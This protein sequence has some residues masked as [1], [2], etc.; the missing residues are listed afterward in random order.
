MAKV[1]LFLSL[2]ES[3]SNKL[4]PKWAKTAKWLSGQLIKAIKDDDLAKVDKLLSAVKT[5]NLYKGEHE[6]LKQ[7]SLSALLLGA[8]QVTPDAKNTHIAKLG[9]VPPIIAP[10]L[11][12]MKALMGEADKAVRKELERTVQKALAQ[13]DKVEKADIVKT[14]DEI[15]RQGA[16][17]AGKGMINITA[18]LHTSR[19]SA[20]GFLAEADATGLTRY[21]ITEQLDNRICPVCRTMH[22]K[23][24]D[25][26][27]AFERLDRVLQVDDPEELKVIA[28]WVKQNQDN[29]SRIQNM[30][31]SD[32]VGAGMS[33]PPYHP[34]CRGLLVK[35]ENVPAL[36]VPVPLAPLSRVPN[37]SVPRTTYKDIRNQKANIKLEGTLKQ[38][39]VEEAWN[40]MFP[41]VTP[42]IVS[43]ELSDMSSILGDKVVGTFEARINPV[44]TLR[45][46]SKDLRTEMVRTL[47]HTNRGLHVSHDLL[48][49]PEGSQGRGAAKELLSTQMAMYEKLGV[50]SITLEANIDVGGYAW[51]KYGFTPYTAEWVQ[52][53]SRLK[54]V[55]EYMDV[56]DSVKASL[57]KIMLSEDPKAIWALADI[58]HPYRDTTVG[59]YLLLKKAWIG[60]IDL[61]DTESMNRFK[62]YTR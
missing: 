5:E 45:S 62:A 59:K 2:E 42:D 16:D 8:T 40:K 11:K 17:Q 9:K 30:T 22:G 23:T 34:G 53:K 60:G 61:S 12:Q 51:A 49:M 31:E 4:G 54:G 37:I 46:K 52:L 3:L 32:L 47:R 29:I 15:V 57:A 19:L 36:T 56:P 13:R 6:Y 24:F 35:T 41:G 43:K 50:K 14:L 48:K 25:V 39:E 18:S 10:A 7:I 21:A 20:Y 55:W 58:T 1:D 28:P 33:T 38:N 26:P 27:Q 44:L